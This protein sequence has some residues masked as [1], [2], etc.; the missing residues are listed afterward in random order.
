MGLLQ[1]GMVVPTGGLNELI[2]VK[3]LDHTW[4]KQMLV[5]FVIIISQFIPAGISGV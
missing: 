1:R 5:I 2:Q 3:R 4:D